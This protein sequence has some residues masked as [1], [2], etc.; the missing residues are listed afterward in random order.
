MSDRKYRQRGYQDDPRDRER[1]GQG[2][3][4]QAKREQAPRGQPPLA[5]KTPNMPGF[6]DVVRCARCG[7]VLS[8]PIG[9]DTRCERCGSELHSCAQCAH[10]DTGSRFECTQPIEARI[11]P[12]DA[13]NA[14]TLF[15]AR[16]TMERETKS[17]GQAP[18]AR[19]AFDDLFKF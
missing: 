2:S 19:Q 3:S 4:N 8:P 12:K 13:K 10:F 16:V 9:F 17:S 18:T 5:P 7:N 1:P 6:R 15:A 11:T 14:C